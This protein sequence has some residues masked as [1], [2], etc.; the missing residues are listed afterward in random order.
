MRMTYHEMT[1][2]LFL[3]AKEPFC[4]RALRK[5]SLTLRMR[6]MWSFISNLGKAQSPPSSCFNGV[7]A[8]KEFLATGEELFSP[9]TICLLPH[10]FLNSKDQSILLYLLFSYDLTRTE[11]SHPCN[12]HPLPSM[13][14]PDF[15]MA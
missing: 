4:V 1:S 2:R 7:S 5:V 12:K 9:E 8:L 14:T 3:R 11:L 10:S 6:T 13:V 15:T